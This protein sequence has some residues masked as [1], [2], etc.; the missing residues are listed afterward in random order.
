MWNV[1]LTDKTKYFSKWMVMIWICKWS[2]EI[3]LSIQSI[4]KWWQIWKTPIQIDTYVSLAETFKIIRM[5]WGRI[6]IWKIEI[7]SKKNE[8]KNKF[9]LV[10]ASSDSFWMCLCVFFF[11]R[12]KFLCMKLIC[13]VLKDEEMAH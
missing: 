7:G 1:K 6:C 8:L 5:L 10:N 4:D 13:F 9:K 11:K 12:H 3:N 2:I